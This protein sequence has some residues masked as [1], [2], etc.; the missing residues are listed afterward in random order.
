MWHRGMLNQKPTIV[1]LQYKS[2]T[3]IKTDTLLHITCFATKLCRRAI[4]LMMSLCYVIVYIVIMCVLIYCTYMCF[5]VIMCVCLCLCVY[6][7]GILAGHLSL[8][9]SGMLFLHFCPIM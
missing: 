7:W 1:C 2:K 8:T 3:N 4:G 6:M 9:H 5:Y